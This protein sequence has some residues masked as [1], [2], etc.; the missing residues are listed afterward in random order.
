MFMVN[1]LSWAFL[2]K[3]AESSDDVMPSH[4]LCCAQQTCPDRRQRDGSFIKQASY[5]HIQANQ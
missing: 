1:H 4:L 5:F 3:E 2:L